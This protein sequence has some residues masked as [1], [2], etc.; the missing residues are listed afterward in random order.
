[1]KAVRKI[2]IVGPESTGKSLLAQALSRHFNTLF[3]PEMSRIYLENAGG[4]W[5]YEDVLTIAKLQI[6]KEDELIPLANK[7]IFCDTELICI[8]VWLDFYR[9]EVP[10]W[11]IEEIHKRTYH[12]F[13][14]MNIDFPWQP[15]PLRQNPNDRHTLFENFK[16][17]LNLFQKPYSIISGSVG[18]RTTQGI[19]MVEY[20]I[21]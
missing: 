1:V 14:L 20:L 4:K 15:D 16:Q 2:A 18:E 7:I 17:Q 3:V 12:H 9:L 10:N 21:K 5:T 11:I 8:K 19:S 13:L 6:Q